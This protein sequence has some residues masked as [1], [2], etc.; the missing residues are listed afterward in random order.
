MTCHYSVLRGAFC[1]TSCNSTQRR[2][3]F[4]YN[5]TDTTERQL[6]DAQAP[7]SH[8]LKNLLW[9]QLS[10]FT[11]KNVKVTGSAVPNSAAVGVTL[12][13]HS[14]MLRINNNAIDNSVGIADAAIL[15]G[16]NHGRIL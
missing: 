10:F 9:L 5:Y 11:Q 16:H 2:T 12:F 6:R 3:I 14:L 8:N 13:Y 15:P 7:D 1:F 4:Y